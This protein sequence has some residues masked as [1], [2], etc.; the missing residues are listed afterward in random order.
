[1]KKANSNGHRVVKKVD[2]PEIESPDELSPLGQELFRLMEKI[3]AS[4]RLT[5][6]QIQK[7]IVRRR[8]APA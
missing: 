2:L 8:G 1:M 4:Q 7:E 5:E 3:P 6:R